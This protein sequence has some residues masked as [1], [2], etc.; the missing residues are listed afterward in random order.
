[1]NGK[2]IRATILS[3]EHEAR[4][5]DDQQ[6]VLIPTTAPTPRPHTRSRFHACFVA[7]L[8]PIAIIPGT[9]KTATFSCQPLSLWTEA[10]IRGNC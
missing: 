4:M 7:C 9:R 2:K 5:V 6:A 10:T 1:M 3:P 8:D